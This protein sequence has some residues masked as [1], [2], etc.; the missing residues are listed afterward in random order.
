[1]DT[2]TISAGSRE[3]AYLEDDGTFPAT[4][5][6]VERKGPFPDREDPNKEYHLLEWGFSIDEAGENS[7]VWGTT[8]ESTG[9]KSKAFGWITAL[10]GKAPPVGFKLSI[11]EHLLNRRALVSVAK[12][13]KGWMKLVS[14]T[15]MPKSPARA[16]APVAVAAANPDDLPF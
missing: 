10:L 11:K 2:L 15:A 4:L 8:S 9:P 6:S 16:A 12:D 3:F 1:M 13:D 7:M 5:V 14:V